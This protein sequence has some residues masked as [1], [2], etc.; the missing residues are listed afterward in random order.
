MLELDEQQ[1]F[2]IQVYRKRTGR[3]FVPGEAT[4]IPT[5]ALVFSEY[6]APYIYTTLDAYKAKRCRYD[7]ET[8][9]WLVWLVT[10]MLLRPGIPMIYVDILDNGFALVDG[11]HRATAHLIAEDEFVWAQLNQG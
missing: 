5:D 6:Q 11:V 10:D 1:T 2:A 8:N 4:A 9:D 7:S 3:I